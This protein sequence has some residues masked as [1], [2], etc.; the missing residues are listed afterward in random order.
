MQVLLKQHFSACCVLS[1]RR[2]FVTPKFWPRYAHSLMLRSHP[3]P[4]LPTQ[5]IPTKIV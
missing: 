1:L 5:L 4:N 2:R 3:T